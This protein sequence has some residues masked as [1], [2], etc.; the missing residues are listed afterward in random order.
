MKLTVWTSWDISKSFDNGKPKCIYVGE[1]E[2]L[3]RVGERIVCRDGF[4]SETVSKVTVDLISKEAEIT[5][6]TR[7]P[8]NEYGPSLHP[9]KP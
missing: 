9:E 4:G 8:Q 5:V 7:D 1:T 3:P 6:Q 2:I